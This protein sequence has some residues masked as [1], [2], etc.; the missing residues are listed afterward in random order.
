MSRKIPAPLASVPCGAPVAGSQAQASRDPGA[1]RPRLRLLAAALLAAAPAL[2]LAQAEGATSPQ[3]QQPSGAG[4]PQIGTQGGIETRRIAPPPAEGEEEGTGTQALGS[5]TAPGLPRLDDGQGAFGQPQGQDGAEGT[6]GEGAGRGALGRNFRRVPLG[7][8]GE[9]L[10]YQ[11]PVPPHPETIALAGARLKLLDKM[12]G[13]VEEIE[14]QAG[15]TRDVERLEV[16]LRAC[17][18]PEEDI[19]QDAYAYLEIRDL[20]EE[21]PRF[22]GWMFASSPALSA[23]DHARY[24]LWVLS[25]NANEAAASSGS[26]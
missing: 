15:E 6:A 14:L 7:P 2:A 26:E 3:N 1:R 12:T 4:L 17:R 10:D 11:P 25:C 22:E 19:R 9:P 18:A 20:R 5:P 23:L 24:D 13:Q 8:D 16:A 21:T